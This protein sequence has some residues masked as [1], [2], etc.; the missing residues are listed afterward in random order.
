MMRT[1]ISLFLSSEPARMTFYERE[2]TKIKNTVYAN[3]DQLGRVIRMRRYMEDNYDADLDLDHMS[4]IIF[5]SKFHLHRL[6]RKYYGQT[7]KQYL[8]EKRLAQARVLLKQG[9][10]VTDTC[11]A[12]GFECPSSF[13]HL[14]KSKT[15]LTPSSFQKEQYSPS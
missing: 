1:I 14:F 9:I 4:E 10:S 15:G 13:C 12:V 8:T 3:D 6:F 7:P 11:F 2:I 5:T